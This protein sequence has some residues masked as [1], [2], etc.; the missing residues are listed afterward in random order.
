[1]LAKSERAVEE[2][3]DFT[4]V[5]V[6]PDLMQPV[7]SVRAFGQVRAFGSSEQVSLLRPPY[8]A[9]QP[10]DGAPAKQRGSVRTV[11]I[12]SNWAVSVVFFTHPIA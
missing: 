12:I 5:G 8:C 2:H 9:P 6:S 4:E 7:L 10:E 1:M 11:S 3:H